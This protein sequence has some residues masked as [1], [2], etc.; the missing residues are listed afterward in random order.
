MSPWIL[1]LIAFGLGSIPFGFLVG[2][3]KGI[4]IRT[5][6]SG[7]I[8]STNVSRVLGKKWGVFVFGLDF[9]KGWTAV[10]LFQKMAHFEDPSH[11]VYGMIGAAVVVILGHNYTPWLGFKGGKGIATSAGVLLGLMPG[12][13]LIGGV[14][15]VL[16]FKGTKTVSVASL[17]CCV[18]V[19]IAAWFLYPDQKS[20]FVFA[21]IAGI[22]GVWRHRSNIRRILA[23]EEFSFKKESS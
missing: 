17:A 6:G 8:G 10:F 21:L 7:N 3:S 22:L 19:P 15:W 4:D 13:L 14:S 16:I 1:L 5:Q 9:L 18:I 12:V 20:L 11:M 23:G 2:K